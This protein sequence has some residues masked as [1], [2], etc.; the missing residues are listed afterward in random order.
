MKRTKVL[1][2]NIIAIGYEDKQH[3]LYVTFSSGSEYV[4]EHVSKNLY[5]DFIEAK[6]KGRFFGINIRKKYKGEKIR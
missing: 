2:S 3:M 4:Y 6:S 5:K 1:S